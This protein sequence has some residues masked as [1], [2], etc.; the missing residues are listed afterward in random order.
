MT[1]LTTMTTIM[2]AM[3]AA[4]AKTCLDELLGVYNEAVESSRRMKLVLD[5][6]EETS[7][8]AP[9]YRRRGGGRAKIWC[10]V[11][12]NVPSSAT[13]MKDVDGDAVWSPYAFSDTAAGAVVAGG[14]SRSNERFIGIVTPGAKSE[15]CDVDMTGVEVVLVTENGKSFL[16]ELAA[17]T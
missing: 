13:T 1:A 12:T 15:F 11:V 7:T 17:R 9:N 2:K 6:D 10:K 8:P 3:N 5:R 4:E 16:Q 14:R